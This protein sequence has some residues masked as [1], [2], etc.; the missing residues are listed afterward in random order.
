MAIENTT[1][2][3]NVRNTMVGRTVATG[4]P[5]GFDV[6]LGFKPK[7]VRIVNLSERIELEWFE[8]MTNAHALK[9]VAAGTRT[10]ITSL[11]ITPFE[12]SSGHG[13]S[14]GLDTGL[15]PT[16][17]AEDSENTLDWIAIE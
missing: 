15:L 6:V 9:T 11:G 3:N 5:V 1:R 12:N 16:H 2:P 14:V 8:G 4:T 10:H 7:Y 17:P 13:F